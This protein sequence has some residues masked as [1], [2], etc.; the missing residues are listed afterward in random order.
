[1]IV[2][3]D[4]LIK[5]FSLKFL[6]K[7]YIRNTCHLSYDVAKITECNKTL[8]KYGYHL[9]STDEG[10]RELKMDSGVFNNLLFKIGYIKAA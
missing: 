1:M 3:E 6:E 8:M 9:I 10:R 7:I 5:C 2:S 4:L